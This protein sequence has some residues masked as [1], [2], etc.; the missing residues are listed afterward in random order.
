M[1]G[2]IPHWSLKNH[3]KGRC[4]RRQEKIPEK[5]KKRMNLIMNLN[6]FLFKFFIFSKGF[7]DKY[8]PEYNMSS[9]LASSFIK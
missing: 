1:D 6:K 2:I 8:D 4:I 5:F 9:I 7:S 3:K